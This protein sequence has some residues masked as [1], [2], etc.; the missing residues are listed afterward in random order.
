MI[1]FICRGITVGSVNVPEVNMTRKLREG[2]TR[3]VNFHRNKPGVLREMNS[4]LAETN[5][6]SQQLSTI[7]DTG[8]MVVDV[9]SITSAKVH[10]KLKKMDHTIRTRLLYKGE[11]YVGQEV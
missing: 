11:G 2:E 9:E 6:V 7:E 1:D 4:A 5:I 10:E 8:F 3:I